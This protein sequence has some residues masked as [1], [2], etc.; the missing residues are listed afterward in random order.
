MGIIRESGYS[1]T[2]EGYF[3]ADGE[4]MRL[5]KTNGSMFVLVEPHELK[6]GTIGQLLVIVDGREDSQLVTLP[7]GATNG[8]TIVNY[9][10]SAPF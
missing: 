7:E 8:E 3:I 6:K 10:V 2:V 5:A 9:V 1:A 4:R